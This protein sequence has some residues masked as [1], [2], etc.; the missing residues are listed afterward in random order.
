[1]SFA[2]SSRTGLV[3][4]EESS[5]GTAPTLATD[6]TNVRFTGEGLNRSVTSVASQEI[7]PDRQ[8]PDNIQVDLSVAGDVSIEWSYQAFDD[9]LEGAL[10]SDWVETSLASTVVDTV[11]ADSATNTLTFGAGLDLSTLT[12]GQNI[13]ITGSVTTADN[14]IHKITGITGQVAAVSATPGITTDVTYNDTDVLTVVGA[15]LTNG[16]TQ[17]SYTIQKQFRDVGDPADDY[18]NVFTGCRI[19]TFNLDFAAGA[20]VTGAFGMMGLNGVMS[21][22]AAGGGDPTLYNASPTNEVMNA[23]TNLIGVQEGGAAITDLQSLSL[24]LDNAI[25]EQKAIGT[26]GNV[27][28][29]S[30]RLTLSGN[31]TAY[32]QDQTL[33]DK[34][35]N[36]TLTSLSWITVDS[37]G[38]RYIFTIPAVRITSAN[39]VAGGLDQDVMVE[40]EWASQL[41][42]VSGVMIQLDRFAA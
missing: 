5:F 26:L 12:I 10:Q 37:S 8:T 39:V 21:T 38:N 27:G 34:H 20:I 7:R 28:L 13:R 35:V 23:V 40:M 24:T 3:Y 30:G 36:N 17:K 16:V 11:V 14:G 22:A 6:Y 15:R 18:F 32:F 1:M 31:I 2:D 4:A 9:L 41:D 29:G 19:S 33:Y 25:R 42:P